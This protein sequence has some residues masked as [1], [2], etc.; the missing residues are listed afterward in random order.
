[1]YTVDRRARAAASS[2]LPRAMASAGAAM[3]TPIR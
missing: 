2:A 3:W 1:M